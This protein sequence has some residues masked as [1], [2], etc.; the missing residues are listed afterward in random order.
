MTESPILWHPV[1]VLL[2]P[3]EPKLLFVLSI[4]TGSV[5]LCSETCHHLGRETVRSHRGDSICSSYSKLGW[6]LE[7]KHSP[8]YHHHHDSACS[9]SRAI[10]HQS[11]KQE[12]PAEWQEAHAEGRSR[13]EL[14]WVRWSLIS[15]GLLISSTQEWQWWVESA[16]GM[17]LLGDL[18]ILLYRPSIA[19]L[20]GSEFNF[21]KWPG[22]SLSLEHGSRRLDKNALP[23]LRKTHGLSQLLGPNCAKRLWVSR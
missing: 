6:K 12:G 15:T 13:K 23:T 5:L 18:P 21:V 19:N 22:G 17:W 14:G 16:M 9:G 3:Q 10:R 11:L 7:K 4:P 20:G 1:I 2:P 8:H